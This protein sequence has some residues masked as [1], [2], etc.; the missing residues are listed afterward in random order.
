MF[1]WHCSNLASIPSRQDFLECSLRETRQFQERKDRVR[2]SELG[3]TVP[4]YPWKASLCQVHGRTHYAYL[5]LKMPGNNR[6]NI[7]V[8]ES[9]S[10]FD[11][12]DREFEKIAT[13][14]G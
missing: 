8:Q 2:G 7:T 1:P 9:L 11:N 10:R 3:I 6:T 4:C 13:N 5:K 14:L 12:C